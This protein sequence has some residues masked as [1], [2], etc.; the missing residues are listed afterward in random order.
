RRMAEAAGQD[1]RITADVDTGDE[2]VAALLAALHRVRTAQSAVERAREPA[3]RIGDQFGRLISTAKPLSGRL[4]RALAGRQRQEAAR[5]AVA[6]LEEALAA[7]A[8]GRDLGRIKTA[9]ERLRAAPARPATVRRDFERRAA[10]YF[11]AL[12]LILDVGDEAD[13]ARGFLPE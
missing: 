2:R 10:D 7:P 3:R 1:V 6:Q 8:T 13:A 5:G 9:N 12:E 4:R 11:A